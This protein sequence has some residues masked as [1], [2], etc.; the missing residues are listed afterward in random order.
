MPL[1]YFFESIRNP[2]MDGFFALIT[3]LGEEEFFL[4]TAIIVFWCV[5]K[6]TGYFLF[7]TSVIGTITNQIAKQV[8]RIPRPWDIDP[9]FAIV[10]D[11]RE[12]ALGYS[13]PSGHTQSIAGTLG[14]VAAINPK[15]WK[16]AICVTVIGLVSFSRMYLGVHTL[17]DVGASLLFALVLILALRPIFNSD[18]LFSKGMPYV[19]AVTSLLSIGFL[20]YVIMIKDDPTLDPH[21]FESG[22]KNAITFFGCTL[23]FVPVYILD[24]KVTKFDTKA[25][26]YAQI[27]KVVLG[28]ALVLLIKEGL[29]FPLNAIF[30]N[31]YVGRAIRY[32]LIVFFAGGIWPFT[33]K[34]FSSLH[35]EPLERF[36]NAVKEK[37][38]SL[39]KKKA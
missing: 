27:I 6:K 23:A 24:V 38:S 32:F 18:K 9:N 17:V 35:I 16:T 1:L 26:W 21:N 19:L 25:T 33:F 4:L 36:G 34:W 13:F 12:M 2:I 30:G 28:I 3:K 22:L 37:L 31:E 29:R 14:T 10:E 15:K 8:C 20:V 39:K 5:N 7:L 11:A